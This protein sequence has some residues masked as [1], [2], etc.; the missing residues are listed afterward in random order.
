MI[1]R[2]SRVYK[3][4]NSLQK[5]DNLNDKLQLIVE[6]LVKYFDAKFARIWLVDKE[7]MYLIL[8]FSAGKYKNIH[9]EFSKVPI[10][11]V[12]IGAIIKTKKPAITNDV[13]NDPRTKHPEWAKKERLKSFA[14][15]PLIYNRNAIGVLAMFSEKKLH[16]TDFEI[17]GIFCNQISKELK[18]FFDAQEFLSIK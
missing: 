12:K 14:G 8:K 7:R 11:S 5:Y 2:K 1:E 3:V 9:G 18:S 17:L 6:N 10:D 15:Y 16:L 4:L 13:V